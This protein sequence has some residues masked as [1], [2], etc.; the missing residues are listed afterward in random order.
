MDTGKFNPRENLL[1]DIQGPISPKPWKLFGPAK[2]FLV[3]LHLKA[4]RCICLK[5]LV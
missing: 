3:H 4:E 2:L 5:R 1:M